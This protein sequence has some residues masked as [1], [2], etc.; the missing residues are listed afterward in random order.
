MT[1]NA[2]AFVTEG[3]KIFV[4]LDFD[5]VINH[6]PEA[7]TPE[8]TA[9]EDRF[10]EVERG[11]GSVFYGDDL[12]EVEATFPLTWAPALIEALNEVLSDDRIQLLWLTSWESAIIPVQEDLLRLKPARPARILTLTKGRGDANNRLAKLEAWRQFSLTLPAGEASYV[13]IDDEVVA[14]HDDLLASAPREDNLYAQ[15][16][17]RYRETLR[18]KPASYRGLQPS[19][20]TTL[21]DFVATTLSEVIVDEK[22]NCDHCE[23]NLPLKKLNK[24]WSAEEKSFVT[25]CEPCF[26]KIV[27]HFVRE[28]E[29]V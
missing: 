29:H 2:E 9:D 22:K 16:F 1:V 26:S 12:D 28:E 27:K 6:F 7:L 4:F 14:F 24:V 10:S 23:E 18:V 13:W 8:E 15:A 25:V 21:R 5:G 17:E 11:Y 19:H 20:I 3:V